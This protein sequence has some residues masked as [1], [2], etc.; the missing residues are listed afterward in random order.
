[1]DSEDDRAFLALFEAAAIPSEAWTHRDHVRVALLYLRELSFPQALDRLRTG[2][3]TLNRVN[4]VKDTPTSGYHETI[5]VAW[6]HLV[7]GAIA[8]SGM[9]NSFADFAQRN[10]DL[11]QKERLRAHY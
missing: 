10:P 8:R 1:M 7:A 9:A 4:G 2:I 5:T 3:Q 6:A 11:L